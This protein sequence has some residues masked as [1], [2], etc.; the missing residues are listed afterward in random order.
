MTINC[1]TRILWAKYFVT[2]LNLKTEKCIEKNVLAARVD[3]LHVSGVAVESKR[4]CGFKFPTSKRCCG[5][6]LNKCIV[7]LLF[8]LIMHLDH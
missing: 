6:K 2:L 3:L 1:V 7:L 5:N 4:C 8:L